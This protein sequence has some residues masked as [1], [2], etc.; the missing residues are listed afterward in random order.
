MVS[1]YKHAHTPAK[2]IN[3]IL[4]WFSISKHEIGFDKVTLFSI[5]FFCVKLLHIN[6]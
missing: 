3:H 5:T 4:G 1:N 6:S 2:I